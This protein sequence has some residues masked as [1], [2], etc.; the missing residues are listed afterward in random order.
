MFSEAPWFN[1]YRRRGE[2]G[3]RGSLSWLSS[4]CP[5]VDRGGDEYVRRGFVYEPVSPPFIYY[6]DSP[7]PGR[8]LPVHTDIGPIILI[9]SKN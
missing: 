8:Y 1:F 6:P 3:T 7:V 5:P 4:Q 2:G 9:G